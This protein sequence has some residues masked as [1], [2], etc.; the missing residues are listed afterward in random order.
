[1]TAD[2]FGGVCQCSGSLFAISVGNR[3][4]KCN[5]AFVDILHNGE[6][7]GEDCE[8]EKEEDGGGYPDS[9]YRYQSSSGFVSRR[10][11]VWQFVSA[12]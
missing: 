5:R 6:R 10:L 11:T 2:C 1:L 4:K 3:G 8:V 12:R 9:L 7:E